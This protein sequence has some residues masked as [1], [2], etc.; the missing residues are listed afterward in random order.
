MIAFIK[1]TIRSLTA[2][3]VILETGGIGYDVQ[4]SLNTYATLQGKQE[5]MLHTI[6]H[7]REDAH[8]LFGFANEAEKLLF[9]N[10]ISVSGIG[11]NTARMI[12]S[13]MTAE[14]FKDAILSENVSLIQSIK[15][16]G[17]KSAKRL[18]L[19]L[20]DKLIRSK[21]EIVLSGLNQHNTI[22]QEALSALASLGISRPVAEKAV[23]SVIRKNPGI[24]SLEMIIKLALK[25]L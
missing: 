22:R 11:P 12:L 8:T 2:G 9:I 15:G 25:D 13:S 7:V 14:E 3:N 10:L 5:A 1:G 16:I 6:L 21:E 24:D 23:A 20:K 19:E 18:I 17:P 4:I